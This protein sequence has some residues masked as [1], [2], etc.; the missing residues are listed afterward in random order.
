MVTKKFGDK[1]I[2]I[3]EVEKSDIKNAKKLQTFINSL[4]D[5]GAKLLMD[6]RA[7]LKDEEE[8]LKRTL[9]SIKAKKKVYLLAEC[10]NKIIGATDIELERWRRNHIGKF[11]IAI[12][13][14]HRG[15]GLGK[16]LM[17]EIIKLAKKDLAPR[18][19]IIQLEVYANN[20]P[21]ISLYKKMGFK[22]VGKIPQQIQH[23]NKLVAEL[24]MIKKV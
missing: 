19:K 3:R 11:G 24:I 6:K 12:V 5:E 7:S 16:H 1:K 17:F 20:K 22:I 15:V 2:V 8:Y 14:D 9:V 18:L 21:A 4:I 13:K 10:N 23:K